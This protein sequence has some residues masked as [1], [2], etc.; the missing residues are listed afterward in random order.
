MRP[1]RVL[2]TV[3]DEERAGLE[4]VVDPVPVAWD[5]GAEVEPAFA[6]HQAPWPVVRQE[7]GHLG[8]AV[9]RRRRHAESLAP[10]HRE[11]DVVADVGVRQE[12]AVK[13]PPLIGAHPKAGLLQQV[14]LTRDIGGRVDQ[15]VT[16]LIRVH[17]RHGRRIAR[18]LPSASTFAALYVAA[19]L[20]HAR[21]LSDPENE[22][23]RVDALKRRETLGTADGHGRRGVGEEFPS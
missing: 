3:R 15:V 6:D 10:Q 22:G 13:G 16:I 11:T 1:S 17:E 14:E 8:R 4:L 20:R 2:G 5:D 23:V 19:Y 9:R 21:V 7:V 18:P 12:D